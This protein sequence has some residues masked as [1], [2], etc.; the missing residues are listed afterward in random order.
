MVIGNKEPQLKQV[1]RPKFTRR[2][3]VTP[4]D[5]PAARHATRGDPSANCARPTGRPPREAQ[6]IVPAG[7]RKAP[8]GPY[9]ALGSRALRRSYGTTPERILPQ[10]SQ[11]S[12]ARGTMSGPQ[13][14]ARACVLKILAF[15]KRIK[16]DK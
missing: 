1:C 2:E 14:G 11:E 10:Y 8:R 5:R 6:E 4:R 15:A 9:G 16:Q 3:G 12:L 13:A 7:T